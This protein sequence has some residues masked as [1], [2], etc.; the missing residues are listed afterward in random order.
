MLR[1]S[2][3][4][5][6]NPRVVRLVNEL[7]EVDAPNKEIVAR[8]FAHGGLS[9]ARLESDGI[10]HDTIRVPRDQLI[11]EPAKEP[12]YLAL[13][14]VVYFVGNVFAGAVFGA[15]AWL[16][17]GELF[18]VVARTLARF[19]PLELSPASSDEWL[20]RPEQERAVR[21]RMYG[22]GLR[23]GP[24]LPPGGAAVVI[25]LLGTVIFDGFSRTAKYA[26]IFSRPQAS[27][28]TLVMLGVVAVLAL[29]YA[30]TCGLASWGG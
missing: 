9:H 13:L 29:A 18:T 16:D 25:G 12:R 1:P 3:L 6:L 11:W 24:P 22:S 21:L 4:K 28:D 19:A 27:R 26:D 7:P 23:T 20:S 2:V 10:M 30:C 14:A 8:L 15:E 17:N 5:Q